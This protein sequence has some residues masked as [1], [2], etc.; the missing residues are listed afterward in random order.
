LNRAK[1]GF[2]NCEPNV[3]TYNAVIDAYARGYHVDEAENLLNE[4]LDRYNSGNVKVKPDGFTFNAVINAWTRSRRRG[5][6]HRAELI[7]KRLL[8]F[9]ENGNPDVKPDSRS[10]SHIID[11]YSRSRERDAGKKAEWLLTGMI[12]MYEKGYSKVFPNIFPFTAVIATYAKAQ[13]M[14]AGVNA[15]RV[16]N[17]LEE[18]HM[19]HQIRGLAPNTFVMN[20]VLHAWSKSAHPMPGKRAGEILSYMDAKFRE[21]NTAL[22]PNTRSY[23][24]VLASW[25]KS[26]CPEKAVKAREVLDRMREASKRSDVVAMNVH[27]YNAVINAAAFTEGDLS[28]RIN[29]FNIASATLEELLEYESFDAIS[30]S[31]GTYIKACG[32]LSLPRAMV[33][34]AIAKAF[35]RCQELG[36]VNDFV[37]TQVRYSTCTSQYQALLGEFVKTKKIGERLTMSEIPESWK[38]NVAAPF[39][40]N[41][42]DRGE[43]W[44]DDY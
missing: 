36:L 19:K 13:D 37:L 18:F 6:G 24:L 28:V 4:M 22:D 26:L 16:F 5:C 11:Y 31:F 27:C 38:S 20:T 7:L 42:A 41:N 17:L 10:F 12:K 39:F 9:H 35:K 21:G 23:G 33:E 29:A 1:E 30:S 8:E 15:E 43:W 44:R 25:S 40:D 14:N 32:K 3:R 2:S 34:P